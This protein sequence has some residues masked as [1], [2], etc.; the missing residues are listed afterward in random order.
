MRL[1]VMTTEEIRTITKKINDLKNQYFDALD[2]F[3][4]DL[5]DQLDKEIV[6]LNNSIR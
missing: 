4:Y 5:A 2:N 1:T 6:R 3:D